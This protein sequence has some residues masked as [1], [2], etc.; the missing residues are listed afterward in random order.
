[1]SICDE[2]YCNDDICTCYCEN[3]H[4]RINE[5]EYLNKSIIST[6]DDMAIQIRELQEKIVAKRDRKC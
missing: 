5:L 1:M 2:C 3:L 4:V 6:I